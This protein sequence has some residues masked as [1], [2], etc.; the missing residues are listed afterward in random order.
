M[1]SLGGAYNIGIILRTTTGGDFSLINTFNGSTLGNAPYSSFVK[2]KDSAYYC[3]TSAG[4]A[5]GFGSIVKICGG[6]ASVF[7][8][9]NKTTDGGYPKGKSIY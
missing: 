2:G 9:F 3:T 1:T 6:E 8:S 7:Y 5:Y 4:G